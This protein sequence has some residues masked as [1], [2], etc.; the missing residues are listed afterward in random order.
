MNVKRLLPALA[1]ILLL[2]T[3]LCAPSLAELPED[4]SL[5]APSAFESAGEPEEEPPTQPDP[6]PTPQPET[7]PQPDKTPQ[8]EGT[9][10]PGKTPQPEGSPEPGKTPQPDK[11]PEPASGT[12]QI[13]LRTPITRTFVRGDSV[14]VD[15]EAAEVIYTL[16]LYQNYNSDYQNR[17]TYRHIDIYEEI[18]R[19]Y[20]GE[21]D[22]SALNDQD[23][24]VIN[25]AMEE[26]G[27][28]SLRSRQIRSKKNKA[29]FSK[30]APQTRRLST[31]EEGGSVFSFTDLK[32][33][34]GAETGN[35]HLAI[36]AG[37]LDTFCADNGNPDTLLLVVPV[38]VK[39]PASTGGGGY[40]GGGSTSEKVLPQARLIVENVH[41][42]PAEP[43]AG[44]E[45][46]IVMDLR[47]TSESLYLQNLKLTYSSGEDAILPVSGSST[48]YI[49]KIGAGETYT[50]RVRVKSQSDLSD[51][52]VKVD[53][54]VEFEDK[55]MN[56]LTATQTV[57][58]KVKQIQRVQLDELT[59]PTTSE[60]YVDES[61]EVSMGVFNMGRTTLY[62]VTARI[63]CDDEN[64]L[65]GASFYGGNMEPG[66][67]KTVELEATPLQE[68]TYNAA[69]ELT[70]ENEDGDKTTERREFSMTATAQ[71]SYD[72]MMWDDPSMYE[73]VEPV[74]TE[75][76][77]L[78]IMSRLP[79]WL[80]AGVGMIVMLLIVSLSV[81]ARRRRRRAMEDDE[82]D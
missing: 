53:V 22:G 60:N 39:K 2:A 50:Q 73:P 33:K 57:V 34:S 6:T 75:V 48:V 13:A 68:G 51:E 44:D 1:A 30:G 3:C 59:L 12:L 23:A 17:N 35:W 56:A 10:E 38:A 72:D 61:Y 26:L 62:N 82:M 67:S 80:Y 77:A 16:V 18:L 81:G 27:S 43:T 21:S 65:P 5:D 66:T 55:K 19:M 42:E 41:T 52:L 36:E 29:L 71:T 45:F 63:V 9:P 46:D 8:P 15:I 49:D 74:Q 40:G 79:W 37:G 25:A 54:S 14:S 78:T 24:H 69:V 11:T 58:I 76:D 70:Y 28:L 4:F 20:M 32:V 31:N 7:T 47:N 64:L